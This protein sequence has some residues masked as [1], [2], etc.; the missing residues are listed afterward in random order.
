[1]PFQ[2][3]TNHGRVQKIMEILGLLAKS[4]DSNNASM[5]EIRELLKPLLDGL[6]PFLPQGNQE[7][8]EAASE[9]PKTI[10]QP[11]INSY[12]QGSPKEYCENL[13]GPQLCT[14]VAVA[15]TYIEEKI[16]STS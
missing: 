16:Y 8:P 3:D 7:T 11:K 13:T 5:D 4:A 6:A 9:T 1:M 14:L 15:M 2:N 10:D 12:P